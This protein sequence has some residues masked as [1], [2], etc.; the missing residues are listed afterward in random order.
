M[1]MERDGVYSLYRKLE[2]MK[3]DGEESVFEHI[4]K[5]AGIYSRLRAVDFMGFSDDSYLVKMAV[6]SL[7]PP[8]FSNLQLE[9]ELREK[10]WGL[11][12]VLSYCEIAERVHN[13][14]EE[15]NVSDASFEREQSRYTSDNDYRKRAKTRCFSCGEIGY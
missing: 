15:R 7:L 9:Y 3:F 6:D 12:E 14:D 1:K 13:K 4:K 2:R 5:M 11:R 8:H 10:D